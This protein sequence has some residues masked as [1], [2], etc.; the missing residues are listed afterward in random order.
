MTETKYLSK[1]IAI[2]RGKRSLA[3]FAQELGISKTT[4]QSLEK[5]KSIPRMDTLLLISDR[6][7][8]PI[9][10]LLSEDMKAAGVDILLCL[11]K[12]LDWFV[13]LTREEQDAVIAWLRQTLDVLETLARCRE[14]E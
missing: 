9:S 14:G 1:N 7:K 6:L 13:E 11:L 5:G 4:L 2:L 10:M 3:E 8:L 12:Q